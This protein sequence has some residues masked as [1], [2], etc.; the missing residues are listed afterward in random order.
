MQ[1]INLGSMKSDLGFWMFTDNQLPSPK[2][3][4]SIL[5]RYFT[6]FDTVPTLPSKLQFTALLSF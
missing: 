5:G 1:L 3:M 4:D 6:T 2:P